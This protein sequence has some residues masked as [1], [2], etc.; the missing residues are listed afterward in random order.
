M[1]GRKQCDTINGCGKFYKSHLTACNHCGLSDIYST[2]IPF[3]P[4]DWIYDLECY[5]NIFTG[6]FEHAHS[7]VLLRFE[8]SEWKDNMYDL[9]LFLYALKEANCRMI[10]FNNLGYDYPLLH[11]IIEA[12]QFKITYVD[13]YEKSASIIAT[14]WENRFDNVIW[15]S[16][17]HITQIDLFKIHHFDN[18]SRRTGLKMLEFNMRSDNI[19]ELPHP[20]GT[21]LPFNMRNELINYND[22]DVDKT[23]DFYFYSIDMIEFREQL[24]EKYNKNFLNHND[25]KLGTDLFIDE[26]EKTIPGSCYTYESG[27]RKPRQTHRDFINLSDVIFPYIKFKHP[28]FEKV[29]QWFESRVITEIKGG[30][31]YLTTISGLEYGFRLGGIHASVEPSIIYSNEQYIIV[32]WDVAGYY[33]EVGTVNHLYP[34]HLSEQ[35]CVVNEKLK[36]MRAEYIKLHGKKSALSTSI[37]LARN[38]AYGDSNMIYSPFFDPKYTVSITVNGQLLLCVAIQYLLDIPG[39]QVIQANT[40]G[41]TVRC[42]RKHVDVMNKICKWW[43]AFT[44]L[45]LEQANYSRM[46]IR[47]VNNYIGEFEGGKLKRKGA[48]CYVTPMED[49]NTQEVLWH[50]NHSMLV[51]PK[52]AEAALVHGK[53][54]R[55]FILNHNNIMDF[56]LRTKVNRS[57]T[58]VLVDKGG[59][60][61]KQQRINRYYVSNGPDAKELLKIT[62]PVKGKKV[63]VWKRATKLTDEYYDSVVMELKSQDH[64]ID[65][66]DGALDTNGLPHDERINTKNKSKYEIRRTG[67]RVNWLVTVYNKIDDNHKFNIN[68]EYYI[69]EAEKLVNPLIEGSKK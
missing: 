48:Y 64:E 1:N 10:G 60:E 17:T 12:R 68:Y 47:D 62:P 32:D 2:L 22:D 46:F 24:G 39:L 11:F 25:K 34:E 44:C 9:L 21:L 18:K 61:T 35:F 66:M 41:F 29:R 3:N 58:V 36:Q 43:E 52:A 55:E 30:E 6:S 28:E 26:L 27:S 59:N 45:E 63:G 31:E 5:P 65:Y 16:N 15:E 51:V 40:D 38:G 8:I 69:K 54:I 42:P 14:P 20:P 57:D 19:G 53:D 49:L 67:L 37:K 7:G 50:K 13:I 23:L 4:L 56:M 33:P